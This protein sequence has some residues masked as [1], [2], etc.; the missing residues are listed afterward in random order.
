M[1]ANHGRWQL[2]LLMRR[3]Q[4][5][6]LLMLYTVGQSVEIRNQQCPL[7]NRQTL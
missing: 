1:A 2:P 5:F 4:V 3:Y 6:G 7:E